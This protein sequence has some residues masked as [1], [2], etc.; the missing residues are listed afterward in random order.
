MLVLPADGPASPRRAAARGD[1]R[2]RQPRRRRRAGRRRRLGRDR[3]RLRR[4]SPAGSRRPGVDPGARL[5]VDPGLW[6]LHL[7][8]LQRALP[9]RGFGLAT[10]VT[11]ELRMV[12]GAGRDR[13]AARRRRT[14]RTGSCRRSRRDA[15]SDAP[16]RTS[17]ARSASGSSTRATTSAS[18]AIVASGPNSASPH[19]D[20]GRAGDPARR[21]DRA[22]HRRHPRRLL[23]G[24]HADAVGHRRRPGSRA[25]RRVPG[26][27]STSSARPRPRRPSAVRPGVACGDL[28]DVARADHLAPAATGTRSS[29]GWATA[30][31]SRRT[32]SRTS[33]PG[34][35][36]RSQP[37]LR[38]QHRARDLPRRSLRRAD[39]GHRRLRE[40]GADV[41]NEAPRD[42]LVVAG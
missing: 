9:G 7:L 17:A 39:R 16:R 38:L 36:S 37:G 32:R 35:P 1:G 42:L 25:G 15:S 40:G 4:S 26:R 30:S 21:S 12:E 22:R 2:G 10:E 27:S 24:H 31:A 34:T 33:S 20:A 29:I 18:F 6:A 28:D 41:L 14:P 5:L 11:R 8:G 19:H 23:L 3:R 13:A